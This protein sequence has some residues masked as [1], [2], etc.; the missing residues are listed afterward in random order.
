MSNCFD[1]LTESDLRSYLHATYAGDS[2]PRLLNSWDWRSADVI[3]PSR[4][5][6]GAQDCIARSARR[7]DDFYVP[8]IGEHIH[9]V[10]WQRRAREACDTPTANFGGQRAPPKVLAGEWVEVFHYQTAHALPEYAEGRRFD[11]SNTWLFKAAGSG[12]WYFTGRTLQ[13]EDAADLAAFLAVNRSSWRFKKP[14]SKIELM[15]RATAALSS[16]YDTVSFAHHVDAG[17]RARNRTCVSMHELVALR[18]FNACSMRHTRLRSGFGAQ[19][20]CRCDNVSGTYIACA[21]PARKTRAG[22]EF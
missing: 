10:L 13:F 14:Q 3:F 19:S 21:S 12:V 6:S 9:E 16:S 22:T 8:P 20:P 11:E 5:P 1:S 17:F 15:G 7:T 18:P 4:L 2:P